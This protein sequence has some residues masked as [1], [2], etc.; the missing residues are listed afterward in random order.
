MASCST[1]WAAS[2]I[3]VEVDLSAERLI[4]AV[5][6]SIQGIEQMAA[7]LFKRVVFFDPLANA[8]PGFGR[9]HV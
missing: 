6:N 5:P 7:T 4:M 1:F 8:L 9:G 2:A 3:V